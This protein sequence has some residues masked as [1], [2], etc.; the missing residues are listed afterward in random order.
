MWAHKHIR[1]VWEA[2]NTTGNADKLWNAKQRYCCD[3]RRKQNIAGWEKRSKIEQ[4][5]TM[6][7]GREK[8]MNKIAVKWFDTRATTKA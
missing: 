8:E 4:P 3:E 5:D 2:N 7:R 6:A 1:Q